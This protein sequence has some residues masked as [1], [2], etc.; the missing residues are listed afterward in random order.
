MSHVDR[1]SHDLGGNSG[2][3]GHSRRAWGHLACSH[4]GGVTVIFILSVKAILH[5]SFVELAR[6]Q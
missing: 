4:W 3:K 6:S 5:S 2:T 1:V